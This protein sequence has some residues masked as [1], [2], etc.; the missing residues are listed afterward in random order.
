MNS[1]VDRRD[2]TPDLE[3]SPGRLAQAACLMEVT[4]RKPGNVHRFEDLGELHFL[5]FL[6]SAGAIVE[7]LD[8]AE[9]HSLGATVLSAVQST[10][11][12]V[13]TNTNLG[14]ILL[15]APLAAVPRERDLEQGVAEVLAKTTRSDAQ[16]VYQAIRLAV[17]GGLGQVAEQDLSSEPTVTLREA[18]AL[19]AERDLVARQYDNGFHEV[20]HEALPSLLSYLNR[21]YSMETTIVATY[22]RLLATHPDSLVSRKVG[23]VR[24][25]EVSRRAG[26]I[27]DA[28]WP[29]REQGKPLCDEFDRWLRA[30]G[31]CLNPGTTA[32]L[33][34]ATLFAALRDGTIQ[35]SRDASHAS[36][37]GL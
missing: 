11:R 6:L 4:A 30:E 37:S 2:P 35:L 7:A 17:P 9:H 18:M 26:E 16:M 14:I 21:G 5:D 24:A 28:G 10:R 34:T 13:T 29:D 25:Q 1:K 20:L 23:L 12:V 32:D 22:L 33:V 3:M 27:L 36:W 31:N 15:L 19:A 8:R